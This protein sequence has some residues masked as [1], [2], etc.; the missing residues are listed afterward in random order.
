M[1]GQWKN[2]FVSLSNI[3]NNL[4]AVSST[5]NNSSYDFVNQYLLQMTV[6]WTLQK[7]RYFN[8]DENYFITMFHLIEKNDQNIPFNTY[9]EFIN[10]LLIELSSLNDNHLS[11]DQ[12]FG[13]LRG[14]KSAI[15]INI[16]LLQKKANFSNARYYNSLKS[17]L[18]DNEIS[19]SLGILTVLDR[20]DF[21]IN[22]TFLGSL[23]EWLISSRTKR[24]GG[25][26]Y[27]PVELTAYIS[28]YSVRTLLMG[29]LG[30][31][32]RYS[33][34]AW[35][36]YF[37]SLDS[38]GLL[39][40]YETLINLTILDPAVGTGQFLESVIDELLSI[41]SKLVRK[42]K[43]LN[44][45]LP[46]NLITNRSHN[47]GNLID[48]TKIT[49]QTEFE[50]YLLTHLIFPK[51]LYG[52]DIDP[53]VIPFT[54]TRLFIYAAQR[55]NHHEKD[56]HFINPFQCNLKVGDALLMAWED[57]FP[58]TLTKKNNFS[59]ILTNPPYIG[60]SDNKELFRKYSVA[61]PTYY[62]GKLNIWYLFFHLALNLVQSGGIVSFLVSNYWLTASGASKLRKRMLEETFILEFIDF[63]ENRLFEG[64]QGIHSS[65]ITIKKLKKHNSSINCVFYT[66]KEP[67][68]S[69]LLNKMSD[70]LVFQINQKN[71]TLH[72]WDDYFH[73]LPSDVSLILN[74]MINKSSPLKTSTYTVKEGLITGLN[75]IT[76]RQI[77]KY[78]YPITWINRGIYVFDSKNKNDQKTIQTFTTEE[79]EYL[80]PLYKSS[81]IVDYSTRAKTDQR[82]LYLVRRDV[83][84]STIPNIK[85]HL[86]QYQTAT[87]NSLDHPPYINRPRQKDIFLSPKL[88]TPQRARKTNFGYSFTEWFAA[89]DVYFILEERNSIQK[90][91]ILL[92]L[93]QSKVSFYWFSWM[94]KKKG[95]QL[96]FFGESVSNFPIPK[97]L[98]KGDLLARIADY[99][100]FLNSFENKPNEYEHIRR[101]LEEGIANVVVYKSYFNDLI[102]TSPSQN[103]LYEDVC[104]FLVK[105]LEEIDIEHF[106]KLRHAIS[107]TESVTTT[108]KTNFMDL[109]ESILS[110][111]NA[112]FHKLVSDQ[113]IEKLNSEVSTS[114]IVE[115]I[116]NYY[117]SKNIKDTT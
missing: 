81:S 95:S 77:E 48:L 76:K 97:K 61:F 32:S 22:G 109:K 68:N 44:L 24:K 91:K 16:S 46:L 57:F 78:G 53:F 83:D 108:N 87:H 106:L 21:E 55:I 89:Q 20:I 54:K 102:L 73:F 115:Q 90:L 27:T 41:Y 72:N 10:S 47:T 9:N 36:T 43:A 92:I 71:L 93:L 2:T 74:N 29:Q 23:Y 52:V 103:Q 5:S 34:D 17:L 104:D 51:S 59:L 65:I 31:K 58:K 35:V 98:N 8:D 7:H 69:Q 75:K 67:V 62:E 86:E 33:L 66:K 105:S 13:R 85:K 96:E 11:I 3:R 49:D 100:I 112:S 14:C 12:R 82:F 25:V 56:F 88:V 64:A 63:K 40:L 111:I 1:N 70:Q 99:L 107:V 94:G 19:K 26:Y 30:V 60:E 15:F 101:F 117:D 39:R 4:L 114:H 6:L 80:R 50:F 45:S 113:R 116:G 42:F 37:E 110:T 28:R 18:S 84:I 79:N 38:T